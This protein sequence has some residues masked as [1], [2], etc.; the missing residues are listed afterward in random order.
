EGDYDCLIAV[1]GGSAIDT[2]KAMS[3]LAANGGKMADWKGPA[4]IPQ[5][6]LP[7][8]AIPTTARTGSGVTPVTLLTPSGNHPEKPIAADRR[9]PWRP[10]AGDGHLRAAFGGPGGVARRSRARQPD[11][12]DRGLCQPPRQPLYRRSC[13]TGDG[14]DR[15]PHPH[16]LRRAPKS[17]R[18]RSDDV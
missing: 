4:A 11:P 2:A 16:G 12:C 10:A 17:A 1:G 9:P 7:M 8:V 6:G 14:A 3:V 13:Q 5:T 18:A 15:G